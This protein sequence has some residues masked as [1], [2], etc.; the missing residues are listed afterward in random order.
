MSQASAKTLNKA[1][2]PI[3]TPLQVELQIAHELV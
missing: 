3:K 2:L 1:P